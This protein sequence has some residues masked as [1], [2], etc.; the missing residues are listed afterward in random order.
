MMIK[1]GLYAKKPNV[2]I[3]TKEED[4]HYPQTVIECFFGT[5]S[6]W[7]VG[8]WKPVKA[9]CQFYLRCPHK[10]KLD[11]YHKARQSRKFS[12]CSDALHTFTKRSETGL[13]QSTDSAVLLSGL[14]QVTINGL[15]ACE[16]HNSCLQKVALVNGSQF[17]LQNNALIL[18]IIYKNNNRYLFCCLRE[19]MSKY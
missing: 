8:Q 1:S 9:D 14:C 12:N 7:D 16:I 4:I 13:G 2:D 10:L 15:Y 3:F 11:I 18:S 5:W 19:Q 6:K 17:L